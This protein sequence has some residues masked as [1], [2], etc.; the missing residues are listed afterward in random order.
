M[1]DGN[2]LKVAGLLALLALG[3]GAGLI[4]T[5]FLNGP[6]GEAQ[7]GLLGT[8]S[9]YYPWAQRAFVFLFGLVHLLVAAIITAFR[10]T[11]V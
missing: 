1:S 9:P 4:V 10:R 3:A 2:K 5:E 6:R 7:P 11:A 8:S